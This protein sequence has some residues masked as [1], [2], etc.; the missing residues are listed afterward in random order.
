MI[1]PFFKLPQEI[2]NHIYSN[3]LADINRK[4]LWLDKSSFDRRGPH[5]LHLQYALRAQIFGMLL[6]IKQFSAE[7]APFIYACPFHLA[8]NIATRACNHTRLCERCLRNIGSGN[9][10]SLRHLHLHRV[11]IPPGMHDRDRLLRSLARGAPGSRTLELKLIPLEFHRSNDELIASVVDY[12]TL[13]VNGVRRHR[14]GV[15]QWFK[16]VSLVGGKIYSWIGRLEP[17]LRLAHLQRSQ[18][19]P[20]RGWSQEKAGRSAARGAR[21]YPC[22]QNDFRTRPRRQGKQP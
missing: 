17:Q 18:G 20:D 3:V 7:V 5:L 4:G 1:F 9:G 6:V 12:F 15:I 10:R 16:M 21:K 8:E 22:T 2:R 14:K 19:A 13:A 11:R